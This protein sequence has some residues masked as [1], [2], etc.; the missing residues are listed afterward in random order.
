[1][2][3]AAAE[4]SHVSLESPAWEH[5]G[6]ASIERTPKDRKELTDGRCSPDDGMRQH[7]Y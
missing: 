1:M 6:G 7:E 4:L 3:P 5:L 2:S